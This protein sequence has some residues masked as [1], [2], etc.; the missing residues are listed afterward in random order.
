M[1]ELLPG[2]Q[3]QHVDPKA[4][5]FT[6]DLLRLLL[7]HCNSKSEETRKSTEAEL[8]HTDNKIKTVIMPP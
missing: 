5:L 1:S 8:L 3:S 6:T 2:T 7:N 4:P